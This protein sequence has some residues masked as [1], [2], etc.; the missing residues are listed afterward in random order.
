MIFTCD[1]VSANDDDNDWLPVTRSIDFA[2]WPELITASGSAAVALSIRPLASS[3]ASPLELCARQDIV[4]EPT[5]SSTSVHERDLSLVLTLYS[6][7]RPA[8]IPLSGAMA[9]VVVTNIFA[10]TTSTVPPVNFPPRLRWFL[11]PV[12]CIVRRFLMVRR[13]NKSMQCWAR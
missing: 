12:S 2:R 6:P 10:F 4:T 13:P 1:A 3:P 9:D 8:T 11:I 7:K 5:R